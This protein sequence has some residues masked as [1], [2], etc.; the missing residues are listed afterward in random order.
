MICFLVYRHL[1]SQLAELEK[2]I[3][4]IVTEEFYTFVTK[5]LNRP[6]IEGSEA[7]DEVSLIVALF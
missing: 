1:G 2:A 3:N 5:D 7:I 4:Q 6:L